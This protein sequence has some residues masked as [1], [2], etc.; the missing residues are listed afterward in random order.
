MARGDV[1]YQGGS[2]ARTAGGAT[3]PMSASAEPAAVAPPA[4]ASFAAGA[5]CPTAAAPPPAAAR[6][7]M[8][9][10]MRSS[11]VFLTKNCFT[12]TGR[13]WPMRHARPAEAQKSASVD[14]SVTA[15]Q[16]LPHQI[17]RPVAVLRCTLESEELRGRPGMCVKMRTD[18]L[19][20]QRWV[21]QRLEDKDVVR[22]G[23]SDPDGA[24]PVGNRGGSKSFFE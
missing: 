3:A 2:T 23:K 12:I 5:A 18:G 16:P 1:P 7:R 20:L 21:Q 14:S 4:A 9:E 24:R 17:G 8:S 19:D 22:S 11:T 6:P 13:V 15:E 10:R